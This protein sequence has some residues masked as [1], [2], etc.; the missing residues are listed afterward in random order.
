MR[1]GTFCNTNSAAIKPEALLTIT[2]QDRPQILAKREKGVLIISIVSKTMILCATS[3]G[4]IILA[5]V[6]KFFLP[7]FRRVFSNA[8]PPLDDTL[9]S[10]LSILFKPIEDGPTS[11]TAL[12]QAVVEGWPDWN[13]SQ[14]AN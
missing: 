11:R 5:S 4:N 13:G 6:P 14:A 10:R 3:F 1:G 2:Q 12:T 8:S 9:S 7:L